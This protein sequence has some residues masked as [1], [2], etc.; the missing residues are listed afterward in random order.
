MK[1]KKVKIDVAVLA[2]FTLLLYG[3]IRYGNMFYSFSNN[4]RNVLRTAS[5]M[6]IM[7]IGVNLCFLIGARD[8]SVSAIAA[9]TSM[10][11][12][13]FCQLN[14][15]L[16][17]FAGLA[18][19]LIMGAINGIVVGKFNVQPFIATLGTQLAARGVALLLNDE[20]S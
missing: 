14:L 17:I 16:G 18:T 8:L 7:A 6:G 4:L 2:V 5:L 1:I 20:Y 11:T 9:L 19:G 3:S 12:A 10:T 13:Y 15:F